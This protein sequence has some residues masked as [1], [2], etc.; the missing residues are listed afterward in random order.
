MPSKLDGFDLVLGLERLK[1]NTAFYQTLLKDFAHQLEKDKPSLENQLDLNR[2][3]A[4]KG[5]SGNLGAMNLF[6][7]AG[8]LEQV[9]KQ[10]NDNEIDQAKQAFYESL[11]QVFNSLADWL[12]QVKRQQ[13]PPVIETCRHDINE[14]KQKL[15]RGDLL[16]QAETESVLAWAKPK[17]DDKHYAELKQSLLTLD[18]KT[19]HQIIETA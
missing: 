5:V 13:K 8:H 11:N 15:T 1:G 6:K 14:L 17:L 16:E 4:I 12:K 10:G 9:I 2:L 7:A 3:H 19:A 18:Y